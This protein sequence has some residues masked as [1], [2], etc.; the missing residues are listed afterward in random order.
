MAEG[1]RG[2]PGATRPP[3]RGHRERVT[4][5]E[6][7]ARGRLGPG[8]PPRLRG[9][10]GVPAAGRDELRAQFSETGRRVVPTSRWSSGAGKTE[11][12]RGRAVPLTPRPRLDASLLRAPRSPVTSC[13]FVTPRGDGLRVP[14]SLKASERTHIPRSLRRPKVTPSQREATGV[15]WTWTA[16]VTRGEWGGGRGDVDAVNGVRDMVTEGNLT[17]GGEHTKQYI[18]I[19][20][21]Y[22]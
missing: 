2:Q 12:C 11:G 19:Y 4:L 10:T 21:P 9:S 3:E 7:R 20:M 5:A 18:Y 17:P 6:A 13:C 22:R 1:T 15:S 14:P 8:T 16:V